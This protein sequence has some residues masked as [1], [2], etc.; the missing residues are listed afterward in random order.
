MSNAEKLA[1]AKQAMQQ[2]VDAEMKTG[3]YTKRSQ[4]LAAVMR[5]R[6]DLQQAIVAA[7]NPKRITA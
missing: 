7:A 6:P 5:N 3:R 1:A 4:A 2:A